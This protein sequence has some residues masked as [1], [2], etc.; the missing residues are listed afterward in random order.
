MPRRKGARDNCCRPEAALY[1]PEVAP[2]SSES[3]SKYLACCSSGPS[4]IN[5]VALGQEVP[6][7]LGELLRVHRAQQ[8]LGR[9]IVDAG[10]SNQFID[11]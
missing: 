5:S 9:D 7:E 3:G 2:Y 4:V 8:L 11:G 6:E 10:Q 1:P